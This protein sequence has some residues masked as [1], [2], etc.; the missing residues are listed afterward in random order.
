MKT[1]SSGHFRLGPVEKVES[2]P[3]QHL[4]VRPTFV[5]TSE[6]AHADLEGHDSR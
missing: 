6:L 4:P 5:A 3:V 2:L 1:Q